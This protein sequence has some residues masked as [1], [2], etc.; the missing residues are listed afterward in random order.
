MTTNEEQTAIISFISFIHIV[1]ILP[2]SHPPI[3]FSPA[4]IG[5]MGRKPELPFA[6]PKIPVLFPRHEWADTEWWGRETKWQRAAGLAHRA[7]TRWYS[8]IYENYRDMSIDA[9][10]FKLAVYDRVDQM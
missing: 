2:S 7:S 6:A 3:N 1:I 4:F 10:Q 8:H 9:V 5:I